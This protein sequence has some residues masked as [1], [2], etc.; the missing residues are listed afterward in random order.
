MTYLI[1]MPHPIPLHVRLQKRNAPLLAPLSNNA[2]DDS[3][4]KGGSGK[5]EVEDPLPHLEMGVL[6]AD[7]DIDVGGVGIAGTS[8]ELKGIDSRLDD[9]FARMV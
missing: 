9:T 4:D 5:G 2:N 8:S 7:V 1:S 3:N 6:R